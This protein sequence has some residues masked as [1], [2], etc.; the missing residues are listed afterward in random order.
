MYFHDKTQQ[1]QF[2]QGSAWQ[3]LT[4]ESKEAQGSWLIFKEILLKVKKYFAPLR[5]KSRQLYTGTA[6]MCKECTG[7]LSMAEP[8][9][10]ENLLSSQDGGN[11]LT[12]IVQNQCNTHLL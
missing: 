7:M 5:G 8:C 2:A 12:I 11:L 4:G 1:F 3:D 10:R 9:G 6:G